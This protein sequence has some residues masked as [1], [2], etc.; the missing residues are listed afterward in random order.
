[1][2]RKGIPQPT[3][4]PE[5][6]FHALSQAPPLPPLYASHDTPDVP[7]QALFLDAFAACLPSNP[8][9]EVYA[10]AL[11]TPPFEQPV[12]YIARSDDDHVPQ[13]IQDHCGSIANALCEISA[14]VAASG[15]GFPVDA[16]AELAHKLRLRICRHTLAK[17]SKRSEKVTAETWLAF[18]QKARPVAIRFCS[19][20]AYENL[21]QSVDDV[22]RAVAT[23]DTEKILNCCR[24]LNIQA[25][26]DS[27]KDLLIYLDRLLDSGECSNVFSTLMR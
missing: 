18:Q 19:L 4:C 5:A 27:E 11:R 13:E 20:P 24:E 3:F 6:Y 25:K 15:G 23:G 9:G 16:L 14:C 17:I 21:I 22:R 12:L 2:T 8:R 1:M 10:V 26:G 7:K